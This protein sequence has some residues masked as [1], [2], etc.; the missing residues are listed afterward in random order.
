MF[1]M[2]SWF[3]TLT[4]VS[5]IRWLSVAEATSGD[6]HELSQLTPLLEDLKEGLK[7]THAKK[8]GHQQR[9]TSGEHG[10][11][12]LPLFLQVG[13]RS[14]AVHGIHNPEPELVC[15]HVEFKM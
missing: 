5:G 11:R 2:P 13:C 9:H 15:N 4:S 6:M 8:A 7:G 12:R 14:C 10:S 3:R 1:V